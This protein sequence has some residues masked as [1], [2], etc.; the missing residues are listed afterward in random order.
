VIGLEGSEVQGSRFRGS[1]F[2]GSRFR[3]SRFRGSGFRVQGS[4]F[5]PAAGLKNG[6][7]NRKRNS[8]MINVECRLIRRRRIE[9]RNSFYFN[10]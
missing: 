6:Q 7:F 10:C 3:G 1:G 2:R 8:S 5:S 4:R 9:L